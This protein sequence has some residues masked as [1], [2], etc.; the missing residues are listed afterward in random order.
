M[1]RK[2]APVAFRR[3]RRSRPDLFF[4]YVGPRED[5]HLIKDSQGRFWSAKIVYFPTKTSNGNLSPQPH[6]VPIYGPVKRKED[7][8][9]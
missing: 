3:A 1:G 7:L 5:G 2:A 8:L 4:E 6:L 9:W